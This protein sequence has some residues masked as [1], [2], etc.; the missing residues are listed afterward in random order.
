MLYDVEPAAGKLNVS[1][2]TIYNKIKLNE[3]KNEVVNKQGKTYISQKLLKLIQ[4]SLKLN[5]DF[6]EDVKLKNIEEDSTLELGVIPA[7]V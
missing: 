4:D 5:S 3:L 1:K 2:M 6:K 7:S